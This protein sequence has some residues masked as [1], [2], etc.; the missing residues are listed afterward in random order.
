MLDILESQ[1]KICFNTN[2]A[3]N[4]QILTAIADH[5]M[6]VPQVLHYVAHKCSDVTDVCN[7]FV[8]R[9]ADYWSIHQTC[10]HVSAILK[11]EAVLSYDTSEH[12]FNM[13][14]GNPKKFREFIS[15]AIWL[16]R[17]H[18]C[19]FNNVNQKTFPSTLS[20]LNN[21]C[22]TWRCNYFSHFIKRY[23]INQALHCYLHCYH[24]S[25]VSTH[26]TLSASM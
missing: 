19:C 13:W 14:C 10:D 6:I 16:L 26:C 25:D 3:V 12:P 7:S 22:Q 21:T 15:I 1:V 17:L 11:T 18:Y 20:V 2:S 24:H 4:L 23:C 5:L 9:L 8:L